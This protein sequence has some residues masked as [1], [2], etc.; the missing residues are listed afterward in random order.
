VDIHFGLIADGLQEYENSTKKLSNFLFENIGYKIIGEVFSD[1]SIP[2]D[3]NEATIQS[4]YEPNNIQLDFSD[5]TYYGNGQCGV[6]FSLEITVIAYYYLFKQDYYCI[7]EDKQPS[8]TDHNDHYY[9]AEEEF[10]LNI[11]GL[12]SVTINISD[13]DLGDFSKSIVTDSIKIDEVT[14]IELC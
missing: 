8:V 10:N 3:N 6:W 9:E 2:D 12:I 4:H 14:S 1:S 13:I 5:V 11:N 7:D